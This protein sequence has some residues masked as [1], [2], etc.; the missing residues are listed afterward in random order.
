MH[1]LTFRIILLL[2]TFAICSASRAQ[3][4]PGGWK[5]EQTAEGVR[6]HTP[7]DLKPGEVFSVAI[8]PEQP[9]DGKSLEGWLRLAIPAEPSL[10]GALLTHGVEA[11][12]ANI[13]VGVGGFISPDGAKLMA[14]YTAFSA[15]QE[16]VRVMRVMTLATAPLFNRYNTEVAQI[17]DTFAGS[18][19]RDAVAAGRGLD[20]EKLPR[21]PPGMKL[22]GELVEGIYV[23]NQ[24]DTNSR[25]G[26]KP[27]EVFRRF[28]LYLYAGGEYRMM[29]ADGKELGTGQFNYD[30]RT[31]KIE[32]GRTFELNNDRFDPDDEYSLYGRDT[33]GAPYIRASADWGLWRRETTLTYAGKVDR[34]SPEAEKQAMLAAEAEASRYKFTVAPGTGLKQSEIAGIVLNSTGQH[35][36][37]GFKPSAD[38]YLLLTDGTVYNNLPVAPDEIDISLSRRKEPE[39]WG[40]WRKQGTQI[41]AAWRDK[42]N[43][44]LPLPGNLVKPGGKGDRM[45]GRFGTGESATNIG[46]SSYR[47]WGVTFTPDGRFLKDE[48]GGMG[49]SSMG[50]PIGQAAVN[51][52]YDDEG[53]HTSVIGAAVVNANVKKKVGGNRSGTY[54]VDGYVMTLT[55]DDGRVVRLPFFYGDDKRDTVW[56]EGAVLGLNEDKK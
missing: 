54:S 9:L 5:T 25:V 56:F 21:T 3:V 42:P 45:R 55:Y 14:F 20:I 38:V 50:T 51:T 46:F 23:G 17:T 47:L 35:V 16:T 27:D 32:V 31:G 41:V 49:N 13:A 6:I 10:P 8:Y 36:G 28:R 33:G 48:R 34:P 15:D 44:F 12:S 39:K 30:S 2:A 53:S 43:E 11:K 24:L 52:M 18:A 7:R 1:T 40:R 26:N 22:G 37:F 19:K 29:S 4:A